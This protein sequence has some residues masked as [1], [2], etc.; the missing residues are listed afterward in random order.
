MRA[1][2]FHRYIGAM[3]GFAGAPLERRIEALLE[4]FALADV[5][6]TRLDAFSS[7]M[8]QKV[9]LAVLPLSLC[10]ADGPF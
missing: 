2:Q 3:F 7:G 1:R 10:R 9:G 6:D 8:I 5:A 4:L